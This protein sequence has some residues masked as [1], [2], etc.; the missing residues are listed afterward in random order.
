MVPFA[1]RTSEDMPSRRAVSASVPEEEVHESLGAMIFLC[2][3]LPSKR[4]YI[5][6]CFFF[7]ICIQ[8]Q[9][10]MISFRSIGPSTSTP[11]KPSSNDLVPSDESPVCLPATEVPMDVCEAGNHQQK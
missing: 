4:T 7:F 5:V 8:K 6:V 2:K 11:F 10:I 1:F 3:T 9:A